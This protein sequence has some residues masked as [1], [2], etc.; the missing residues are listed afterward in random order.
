MAQAI[1]T[2]GQLAAALTPTAGGSTFM[3]ADTDAIYSDSQALRIFNKIYSELTGL[4]SDTNKRIAFGKFL[5][6]IA[7][8]GGSFKATSNRDIIIKSADNSTPPVITTENSGIT[9]SQLS[10]ILDETFTFYTPHRCLMTWPLLIVE[11]LRKRNKQTVWGA[12]N[13]LPADCFLYSFPGAQL[14]PECPDRIKHSLNVA[15]RK[16]ILRSEEGR[17]VS[18]LDEGYESH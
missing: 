7:D 16:A 10:A 8:N 5:L 4:Q 13:G 3:E 14:L 6:W 9:Y 17:S 1:P 2:P 18:L 12:K 15:S 11:G